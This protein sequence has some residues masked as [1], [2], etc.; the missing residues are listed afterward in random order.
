[1]KNIHYIPHT[2]WDREW[3]R[4][5]EAFRI[6][7]TYSFDMLLD[8]LEKNP[9]YKYF[10]FDGQ[11]GIIEDYLSIR[12]ENK[13]KIKKYISQKRILVGPW[14]IQPD[15]FLTS[16]ES[17]LRNLVIGSNIAEN[18]GHCM[19]IGWIPDSFGQIQS[20]P[21][22]FKELGMKALFA[23][24]GFNYRR[25]DDSIFLW[26]APNGD[27]IMTVHFPLGYGHYRYL[28][29]NRKK[30]AEDIK[31]VVNNVENRFI[32]NQIL[33]MG[34]SDHARPQNEITEIIEDI[35]TEFINEGYNIKISNPEE[36]VKDVI[37]EQEKNIREM[38]I[39]KG[40]ARSAD[41]GRIHAGIS[42]TRIDIK[43][44]MKEYET[45]LPLVAEPMSVI[46][47]IFGGSYNQSISNFFW[48]ILFKNQFH[49]SIYSSSPET[50]NG[51]VENR[52]LNLRH[53]IN[54]MI[55]LNFRYLRDKIDFSSLKKNEQPIL[56]F[57]TLPYKRKDLSFIN[58]YVKDEKFRIT[59]MDGE[60]VDFVILDNNEM[61]NNEIEYYNGLLNLNDIAE[62]NEG[63]MKQ[64]QIKIK[65]DI[66]PPMGYKVLKI[67]YG[68]DIETSLKTD[69]KIDIENNVFEN[70]YLRVK[71]KEDGSL[72]IINK[73]NNLCY[74][75]VHYFE[76][77]GDDGDEYNYSPP[78][79]DEIIK[80]LGTSADIIPIEI[81]PLFVKYSIEHNIDAPYE[82]INH[83][84]SKERCIS[85]VITE[86]TLETESRKVD[87]KTTI[88]N[89]N[90]DHMIRVVF[91]DIYESKQSISE[92]HFGPIIRENRLEDIKRLED[93]ATELELPIYPMQG[94]TMLN[95][96]KDTFAVLSKGPSEYEI[97][98]DKS[99]ALTLLRS[100]GKFG[101]ADLKTRPGRASGY[102][103]DAPS[104]QLLKDVTSEYSLYIDKKRSFGEISREVNKLKV[105]TFTRLLKDFSREKNNKLASEYS[106][107]KIDDR[108]DIMTLKKCENNDDLVLRIKNSNNYDVENIKIEFSGAIK[109]VYRSSLKENEVEILNLKDGKV[110]IDKIRRSSFVTLR[111]K[112][113]KGE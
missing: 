72:R 74:E 60:N 40:E 104:S 16:G 59:N 71:I 14:Y 37:E 57:N 15:L 67:C 99:I 49:D 98:D 4:S 80:T 82:C 92:D 90:K 19:E 25:T 1:M 38:E 21:Q 81:N 2:H 62:V 20:T 23:W 48:K 69:I 32:D 27:K 10:T 108:V 102:R 77:K 51:S 53:G 113:Y 29:E 5:S 17:I 47:T 95:H 64:V 66:V 91:D 56:I 45:V 8:I 112:V 54:E 103:L 36:F 109:E 43:N 105:K 87:F 41:L 100:V 89:C 78:V 31:N 18:L 24:R 12:P 30:A 111:L 61:I 55:W 6:R 26:E 94:Y 46:N 42:S 93:G 65:S 84:R 28:P 83:K 34:G 110:F 39:Y 35:K 75:N 88:K 3:Y 52:L 7:L 44:C 13:E 68:E 101:K 76:E 73:E 85:K 97:Y 70:K 86:L 63:T 107:M 50:V 58:L 11:T 79:E 9:K 106:L 33:F 22:I 96:G